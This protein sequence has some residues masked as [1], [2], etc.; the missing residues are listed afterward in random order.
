MTRV[1]RRSFLALAGGGAAL[2]SIASLRA[3]PAAALEAAPGASG[4]FFAPRE[5]EILTRIVERLVDTG[6][7]AAPTV[8]GTGTMDT[9]DALCLG[10]DP[11]ATAPLPALIRLVEWGPLVF[12]RR[13]ARFTSLD[14]AGQDAHLAGWMTSGL[15][16]RRMGFHA[17]R[18]LALLGYWSQD[19]TWP[20]AG[21]AGPLLRKAGSA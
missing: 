2:G 9:I 6:D 19:A 15:A 4:R 8:R 10:L 14:A 5:R 13:P 11:N 20:L 12:E 17:L 21:Y 1:T 3:V 16:L 7:P 18:N